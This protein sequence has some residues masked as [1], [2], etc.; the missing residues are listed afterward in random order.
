MAAIFDA[1]VPTAVTPTDEDDRLHTMENKKGEVPLWA[2][3]IF[4]VFTEQQS[5]SEEGFFSFL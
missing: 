1:T 3:A 5:N 4:L 2:T